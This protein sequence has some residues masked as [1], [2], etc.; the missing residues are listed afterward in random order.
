MER[1]TTRLEAQERARKR[2][3]HTD[4]QK[5]AA[6]RILDFIEAYYIEHKYSPT[7]AEIQKALGYGSSSTIHTYLDRMIFA[8]FLET[9]AKTGASRAFRVPGMQVLFQPRDPFL[10][11]TAEGEE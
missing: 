11:E 5:R 4:A 10:A 8:G 9:D 3:F 7:L 6:K 2:F 1:Y